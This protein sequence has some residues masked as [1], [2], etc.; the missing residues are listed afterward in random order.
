MFCKNAKA[1]HGVIA[2]KFGNFCKKDQPE[3]KP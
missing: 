3:I 2:E 1:F